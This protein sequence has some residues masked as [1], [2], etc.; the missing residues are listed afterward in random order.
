MRRVAWLLIV[1]MMVCRIGGAQGVVAD[2]LSGKLIDPEV[3]VFA[4]YDL[5]DTAS[6]AKYL[7]R[8][9]IVGE[10]LVDQKTGYWVETEIVPMEGFPSVY[11]MLLTGPANKAENVHKII[12]RE[13]ASAPRNMPIEAGDLPETGQDEKR[14]SMGKEKVVTPQGE[15]EA[16]HV[17]VTAD[18]ER[19]ELWLNEKVRPLGLVRMVADGGE[20]TLQRFGKGGKDA[21]SNLVLNTTGG[22]PTEDEPKVNV[23]VSGPAGVPAAPPAAAPEVPKAAPAPE[24]TEPPKAKPAKKGTRSNF[25]GRK[26]GGR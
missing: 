1:P 8:Q 4:W 16:E 26:P 2:V 17:V 3:G 7:L 20:L 22:S 11:K 15:I 19:A 6:G 12:V 23:E 24:V 18:G 25:G 9:A 10:E 21:E 5:K 14:E 13:G